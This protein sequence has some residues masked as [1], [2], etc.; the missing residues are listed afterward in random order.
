MKNFI[1]N[2]LI[3]F[4]LIVLVNNIISNISSMDYWGNISPHIEILFATLLIRLSLLLTNKFSCRYPIL[5]YLLEFG[6]VTAVVFSCGW[7]FGW[8]MDIWWLV[9]IIIAL[10]YTAAYMLDLVKTGRD[11][12]YINEQIK[13]R[14]SE[15][16]KKNEKSKNGDSDNDC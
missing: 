7:L 12:A 14:R 2:W 11:I 4:A 8:K 6:T 3:T 5:E 13:L 16:E 9:I 15:T 1:K 10:V